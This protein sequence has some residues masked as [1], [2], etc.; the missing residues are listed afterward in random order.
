MSVTVR[1]AAVVSTRIDGTNNSRAVETRVVPAWVVAVRA[2]VLLSS[3]LILGLG[4]D[5]GSEGDQNQKAL[6]PV[7]YNLC[8]HNSI[9]I[10]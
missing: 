9:E 5:A 2:E 1:I 6:Q 3:G 4:E 10:Q 7:K 8:L